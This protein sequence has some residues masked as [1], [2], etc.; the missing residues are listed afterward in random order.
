MDSIAF[1]TEKDDRKRKSVVDGSGL[2]RKRERTEGFASADSAGGV[3]SRGSG[4]AGMGGATG[5]GVVLLE[6]TDPAVFATSLLSGSA[7]YEANCA[8]L[9]ALGIPGP[10]MFLNP[11]WPGFMTDLAIRE[12]VCRKYTSVESY[13]MYCC[14]DVHSSLCKRV[15][16]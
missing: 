16:R 6:D 7:L 10:Q 14:T 8:R 13:F 3:S 12:K 1:V 11:Q 9:V 2:R 5:S 15:C 4:E